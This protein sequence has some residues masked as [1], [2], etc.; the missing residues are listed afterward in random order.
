MDRQKKSYERCD[1]ESV[2]EPILGYIPN[3]DEK[4]NSGGKG[5]RNGSSKKSYERRDY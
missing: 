1:Y 5:L 4:K 3:N 2:D